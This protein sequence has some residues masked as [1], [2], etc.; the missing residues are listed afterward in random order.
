MKEFKMKRFIQCGLIVALLYLI[1]QHIKAIL[2]W[3][4]N[5]FSVA[6]PLILG[7]IMAYIL[8]ILMVRIEKIYFP[9]SK[10]KWI[11]KSRRGV[12]ITA[13]FA[14]L[15]LIVIFVL[16]LV[17]PQ[18]VDCFVIISKDV[19]EVFQNV[20]QFLIEKSDE[21]PA[22]QEQL[23]DLDFDWGNILNRVSTGL[24]HGTKGLLTSATTIVGS[25]FGAVVNVVV[26]LIFSMY[27]LACKEEIGAKLNRM[28]KAFMKT[29]V[30]EKTVY[31]LGVINECFSNFIVGQAT[32][33][34]ILGSLCALGMWALRLPY[35]GPIGALVGLT[36]LIP[37]FGAY[38]GAA[39][40]AFMIVTVEPRQALVFLIFL[41]ILQQLEGNL[42]YPKVVGSSIGLPGIW[43]L[44]AIMIGS[45]LGGVVGM[46]LGVPVA[47]ACYKLLR[48]ATRKK[49][50]EVGK[51]PDNCKPV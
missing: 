31:V 17:I 20:L 30:Y 13:S 2:G 47:A 41:V 39:L 21:L 15:V 12:C 46:L 23:A 35:A 40:G 48:D 50:A 16:Y 42:I 51:L 26:G 22:L 27:V 11:N 3:A 34:I 38:I 33:A 5:L 14:L 43:V 19:P 36:A 32:E 18:V 24:M 44:A 37:I 49:E 1:V 9:G 10:N 8:N 7:C 29:S 4:G 6:Y 45:G 25:F 28:M